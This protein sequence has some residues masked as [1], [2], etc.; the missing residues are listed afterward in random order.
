MCRFAPYV[1]GKTGDDGAFMPI[2][3]LFESQPPAAHKSCQRISIRGALTPC[4][5]E[6]IPDQIK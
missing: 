5:A 1:M 6:G 3:N 4:F 2:A